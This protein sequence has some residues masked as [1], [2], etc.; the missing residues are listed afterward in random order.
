MPTPAS[1]ERS[2]RRSQRS[3]W[4]QPARRRQAHLE[5]LLELV[6]NG[7]SRTPPK[8]LDL[9][10]KLPELANSPLTA[11]EVY[12]ALSE[13]RPENAIVVQET[14]SNLGDLATWWPTVVPA[15]Y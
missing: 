13:L 2:K 4:R 9:Q 7:S 15:S 10:R 5:A 3:G 1:H 11:S 6:E 12:A 8:P 14:P